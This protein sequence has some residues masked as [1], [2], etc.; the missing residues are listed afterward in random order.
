MDRY[1]A[2]I[3]DHSRA[4]VSQNGLMSGVVHYD[5]D[6]SDQVWLATLTWRLIVLVIVLCVIFRKRA[7]RLLNRLTQ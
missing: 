2:E 4:T 3:Y 5:A 6:A 7:L 1:Q